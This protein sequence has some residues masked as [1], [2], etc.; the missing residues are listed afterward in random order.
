[1]RTTSASCSHWEIP[2]TRLTNTTGETG[3]KVP[4]PRRWTQNE[5]TVAAAALR[6]SSMA[7]SSPGT[8]VGGTSVMWV[9][10]IDAVASPT[11]VR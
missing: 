4:V 3:R 7:D 11:E 5:P 1:M 6:C 2:S 10:I 9:G 8:S